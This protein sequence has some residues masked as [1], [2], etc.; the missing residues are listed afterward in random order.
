M[1][2]LVLGQQNSGKSALAEDLAVNTKD[3]RRYYLATMKVYDEE[4]RKRV[5]D[6]RAK[7]EGKG[8]ITLEREYGIADV[9][10]LMEDPAGATLLLECVS[11]LV[12]NELF[13]NPAQS[14]LIAAEGAEVSEAECEKFAEGIAA[15]IMTL[16]KKVHHLICVSNTYES[17]AASYDDRT[18]LYVRLLDLVN[19]KLLSM[20]DQIHDL[21]KGTGGA[22][23]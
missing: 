14:S 12:G 8:F 16:E 6:H 18:R 11:N 4:G 1:L 10:T 2:I 3:P 17:D 19:E 5:R 23:F 21:R 7:R 9:T 22:D 20:A 15:E 13:E